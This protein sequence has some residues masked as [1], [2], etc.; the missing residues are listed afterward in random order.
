MAVAEIEFRGSSNAPVSVQLLAINDYHGNIEPPGGSFFGQAAGGAEYLATYLA[1]LRAQNP[2]TIVVGAGDLIGASPL[3]SALF[4]DEPAIETLNEAGLQVTSVGNHEFDEGRAELL[5][6]QNGG[7]HP[8]DGCQDGDTF[9]GA[10]FRYLSANVEV[11]VTDAQRAAYRRALAAY[12]KARAAHNRAV[13]RYKQQLRAKRAA[14]RANPQSAACKRKLRA[15]KR[16]TRKRPAAPTAKPLFPATHVMTVGGVRVGF[17]GMTLEGTPTIVT[18][19]GVAGLR[20]LDEA[21]TAN[22]YAAQLKA[23]GVN[24]IV[25]L[26]HEGGTQTGGLSDCAGI[27]G[28]LLDIVN[29]MSADIDVVVSGHTHNVYVCEIGTKLVTSASAFGRVVTDIDLTIE[30]SNGEVTAKA[31]VNSIVP[32]TIPRDAEETAIVE[33]YRRLSAPLA[34]RVIGSITGDI[35]RSQTTAGES[36]LGDV[37]ADAQLGATREAAKG[38]AVMAFMNPGGIRADLNASQISGGEQAGQVTFGEAFTVQPFG[39]SLVTM[40]LTGQQIDTLLE[41]QWSGGNAA[42]PRILQVSNGLTYTWDASKPNTDRVNLSEIQL[43]G[44]PI[45]ATTQYRVTVNSFLAD[46]GDNFPILRDGTNRLGGDVDLDALVAYFTASSP[47]APGPRNR[48]TRL[49]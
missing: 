24:A 36:A 31:A 37:I 2:N 16:F 11:L 5:R 34:N 46:G 28:A 47:V 29:R 26:I 40:T 38:N 30:S 45:G 33:K 42:S 49:N 35:T 19:S 20:F 17:I 8:R 3:I 48:I 22:R 1:Q 23:Q 10:R 44:Q 7:C 41:Q 4:H 32:R 43:N 18:P 14:C 9:A 27:S 39:N 25:V 15:P 12:T 6:M 13:A 21:A